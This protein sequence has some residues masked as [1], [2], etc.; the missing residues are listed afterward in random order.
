MGSV[1]QTRRDASAPSGHA[2]LH[3]CCCRGIAVALLRV[4]TLD[5]REPKTAN[6]TFYDVNWEPYRGSLLTVL[7]PAT[8][9]S[10]MCVSH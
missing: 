4:K 8:C 6:R 9:V 1:E 5:Y 10:I 7:A 3:W 2:T